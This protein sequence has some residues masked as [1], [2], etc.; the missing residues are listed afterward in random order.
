L[1]ARLVPLSLYALLFSYTSTTNDDFLFPRFMF[2]RAKSFNGDVSSWQTTS[3]ITMWSMFDEAHDF[4]IDISAWDVSN[5]ESFETMFY[6]ARSFS[7]SLCPWGPRIQSLAYDSIVTMFLLTE[8]CPESG[9]TPLMTVSPP[10]PFCFI[11]N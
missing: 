7:Q 3:A 5:V 1:L 8:M 4:N 10:G 6:G 11:C 9:E 2:H